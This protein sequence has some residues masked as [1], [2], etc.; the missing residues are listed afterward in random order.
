M[1]RLRAHK[2]ESIRVERPNEYQFGAFTAEGR[3]IHAGVHSA[4]RM[5]ERVARAYQRKWLVWRALEWPLHERIPAAFVTMR[6]LHAP[7][8]ETRRFDVA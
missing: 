1:A 2:R 7:A 3:V 5:S 6:P 4:P 8:T